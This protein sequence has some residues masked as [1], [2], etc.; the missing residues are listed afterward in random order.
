MV[1]SGNVKCSICFSF[2][3]EALQTT[4]QDSHAVWT[5]YQIR[6]LGTCHQETLVGGRWYM[7]PLSPKQIH[8]HQTFLATYVSF[9]T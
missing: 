1:V 4:Y 3:P 2:K 8:S 9:L 5:P 6:V 7:C